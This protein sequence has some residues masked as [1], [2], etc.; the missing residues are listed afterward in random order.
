MKKYI[1]DGVIKQ[2]NEIVIRLEDSVVINPS[3]QMVLEH[4]WVEYIKPEPTLDTYKQTKIEEISNYDSSDVVNIFYMNDQPIWLDKSTR[5]GLMLRF[6]AESGMGQ[7]ETSLWY[8]GVEFILPLQM[9][10]QMLYA[11]EIY[12]S[13]CYDYTQKHLAEIDKITNIDDVKN[14][15]YTT[16]YPEKLNFNN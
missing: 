6:Q 13:K 9:A 1:K 3:T 11:I 4:G 5:T 15:D 16:G 2:L 7:T 10:I 12:A 8:E 14:Y